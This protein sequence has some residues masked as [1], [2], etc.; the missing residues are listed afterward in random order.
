MGRTALHYACEVNNGTILKILLGGLLDARGLSIAK[1]FGRI[2]PKDNEGMTPLMIAARHGFTDLTVQLL[3]AARLLDIEN[4]DSDEALKEA[5]S[6]SYADQL[7]LTT[8]TE[9]RIA[10][11]HAVEG[12]SLAAVISLLQETWEQRFFVDK[13]GYTPLMHAMKKSAAEEAENMPARRR[14][15]QALEEALLSAVNGSIGSWQEKG[16]AQEKG[17]EPDY[18]GAKGALMIDSGTGEMKIIAYVCTADGRVMME[19]LKEVKVMQDGKKV[20]TTE[21]VLQY[22]ASSNP[23]SSLFFNGYRDELLHAIDELADPGTEMGK[24]FESVR[25]QETILG[26]TAWYRKLNETSSPKKQEAKDFLDAL[27][28]SINRKLSGLGFGATAKPKWKEIT[29]LEEAKCEYQAITYAA[30]RRGLKLPHCCITGGSGSVQV[31]GYDAR[32][33]FKLPLKD[34]EK[35]LTQAEDKAAKMEELKAQIR[36]VVEKEIKK[37]QLVQLLREQLEQKEAIHLIMIGTFFYGALASGLATKGDMNYQYVNG[38]SAFEVLDEFLRKGGLGE[39]FTVN[40]KQGVPKE[41]D[42]GNLIRLWVLLDILVAAKREQMRL[43]QV[44]FARDW[45]LD[46]AGFRTTWT[47]GYWLGICNK[48]EQA[49]LRGDE[50]AESASQ[51]LR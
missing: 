17:G 12:G 44:L 34:F 32:M 41:K 39:G 24:K 25:F 38:E 19:E 15:G 23:A 11:L 9:K 51:K 6:K 33:S 1:R 45:E 26:A 22:A 28:E 8:D 27:I 47:A 29:D 3:D 35:A 14:V 20:D 30:R 40:G 48:E 36:T 13:E 31:I 18:W 49:A 50:Q 16:G 37:T 42:L 4:S 21:A 7:V 10:L 43:V 5:S 46:G 2:N